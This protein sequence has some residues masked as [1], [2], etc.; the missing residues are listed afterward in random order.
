M[1]SLLAL[2]LAI[3]AA[4]LQGVPGTRYTFRMAVGNDDP[5]VG[6]VRE[7]TH[8]ARV[9]V[10][11]HGEND[12]DYLVITHDGHRVISLHPS[13]GEYSVVGDSVFERIAAVGL[14]AVSGTGV[15]RFRVHDAHIGSERWTSAPSASAA[16]RCA[17]AW[18]PTSGSRRGRTCCRIR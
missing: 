15:V 8:R 6:T 2:S 10:R 16:T 17:S 14:Q 13:D 9:D 18:S 1:I 3:L 4:P 5:I 12:D 11:K 7:G